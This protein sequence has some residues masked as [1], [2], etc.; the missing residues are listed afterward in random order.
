VKRRLMFEIT[1]KELKMIGAS[2]G[3]FVLLLYTDYCPICKQMATELRKLS[4][5]LNFGAGRIDMLHNPKAVGHLIPVGI[6]TL[7]I[8]E[9]GVITERHKGKVDIETLVSKKI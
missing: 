8:F 2:E 4:D 5:K 9:N 3:L 6:P 1:D 7:I